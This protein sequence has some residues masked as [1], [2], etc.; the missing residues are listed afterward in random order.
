[1][2]A[3]YITLEP[4]TSILVAALMHVSNALLVGCLMPGWKGISVRMKS[5]WSA[6]GSWG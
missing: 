3:N 4:Q 2:R 5:A 6:W 1:M